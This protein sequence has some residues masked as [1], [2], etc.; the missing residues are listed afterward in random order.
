MYTIIH[1]D[2]DEEW[3]VYFEGSFISGYESLEAAKAAIK[4]L[5][6]MDEQD[7]IDED[8]TYATADPSRS[9]S[10]VWDGLYWAD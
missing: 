9:P 4:R 5:K 10:T 8:R 6:R 1:K 2:T 3:Y 7:R